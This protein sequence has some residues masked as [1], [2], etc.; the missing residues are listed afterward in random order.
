MTASTTP[1]H[2]SGDDSTAISRPAAPKRDRLD[3]ALVRLALAL[4]LGAL[5]AGLDSTIAN[6]AL[7]RIGRDFA[8]SAATVQWVITGYLLPMTMIVPLTGWATDRFGTRT[9]WLASLGTF[10]VG[11]ILCGIAWSMPALIAFRV[12][13]GAGGW[14]VVSA[15]AVD[16][17]PSRRPGTD[18]AGDGVRRRPGQLDP[19]LLY[20]SPS[21][22]D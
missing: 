10:M 18:G 13:Q 16:P 1:E 9:M 4:M 17:R 8:V 14:D 21:P 2:D 6:V 5:A 7:D 12:L 20:T 15:G 3:P 19:C 11:S 22:R